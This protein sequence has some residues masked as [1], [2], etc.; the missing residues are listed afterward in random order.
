MEMAHEKRILSRDLIK[1]KQ[2]VADH[3]EV[4]TPP[5]LVDTMLELTKCEATRIDSRFLEPG[6]GTGNFLVRVLQRKLETVEVQYRKSEFDRHHNALLAVMSIYGVEL[7]KDNIIE[8]RSKLLHVFENFLTTKTPEVFV[9]AAF[10]VLSLNLVHGDALDMR[11]YND[12]PITFAE[13]KYLG[14]GLF[15]RQDYRLSDLTQTPNQSEK[16]LQFIGSGTPKPVKLYSPMS[17]K[18][19]AHSGMARPSRGTA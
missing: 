4:F 16:Q 17:V 19:L 15:Q 3:G 10:H 11:A 12:E 9:R 7:L 13:W 1:S 5:W 14:K 6:C 8:C 18:E 2:R